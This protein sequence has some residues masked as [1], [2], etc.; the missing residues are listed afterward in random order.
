MKNTILMA[1]SIFGLMLSACNT[2]KNATQKTIYI[3]A[4]TRTCQL[5]EMLADCMQVKWTKDQINW[6][7][8]GQTTDIEGFDYEKGYEYELVV[9]ET[10]TDLHEGVQDAS[11]IKYKLIT[12]VSKKKR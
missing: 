10:K 2:P 9:K 4:E 7:N 5:G 1:I 11:A 12:Q 6:E 3:G 8:F